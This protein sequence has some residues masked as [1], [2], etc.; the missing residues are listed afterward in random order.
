MSRERRLKSKWSIKKYL[1]NKKRLS[2]L[3]PFEVIE[4]SCNWVLDSNALT[5]NDCRQFI[6]YIGYI[7]GRAK[8]EKFTNAAHGN[9]ELAVRKLAV[10]EVFSAFSAGNPVLS[11]RY[12][13][14][15]Y[16]KTYQIKLT[17]AR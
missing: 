6:K 13:V 10:D 4:A 12:Y 8:S 17:T 16:L 14:L 2:Q 5:I 7:V 3:S 9:Y 15:E 1:D 11:L